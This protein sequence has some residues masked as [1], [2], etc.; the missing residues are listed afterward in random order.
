MA[1]ILV[2]FDSALTQHHCR[3]QPTT[4]RHLP[5]VAPSNLSRDLNQPATKHPT[6]VRIGI[7]MKASYDLMPNCYCR[8]SDLRWP[9]CH[10]QCSLMVFRPSLLLLCAH[11][12]NLCT[13]LESDWLLNT[14]GA[15]D[16]LFY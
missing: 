14:A 4:T 2:N 9:R 1:L 8:F 12:G 7:A 16:A 11:E 15:T 5:I 6:Q 10:Q 3:L 13:L